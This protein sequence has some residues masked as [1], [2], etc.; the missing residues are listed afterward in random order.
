MKC[1]ALLACEKLIID[2]EGAHSIINVMAKVRVSFQQ[3]EGLAG[4]PEDIPIPSNAIAGNQ[5]WIYSNW[6][7][8]PSD[9]GMTFEQVYQ[10][11]WPNQ[12][13][14]IE[15]RLQAFV[16]N[17]EEMQQTSFAFIGLPV[18]QTG[19]IKIVTWLDSDG[20]RVSEVIET[21]VLVEHT[22]L[23]KTLTQAVPVTP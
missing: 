11:Y 5:W 17:N 13:K 7:P 21:T 20:H 9:V 1:T 3:Q 8:S 18:G 16:Q 2:K 12:E 22:S 15:R 10:I 19:K 14:L 6:S 23:P 4:I